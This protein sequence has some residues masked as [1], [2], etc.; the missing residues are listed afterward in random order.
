MD[1]SG[2]GGHFSAPWLTPCRLEGILGLVWLGA[3]FRVRTESFL[4]AA[5]KP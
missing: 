3:C 1:G 5:Y 2:S 4:R